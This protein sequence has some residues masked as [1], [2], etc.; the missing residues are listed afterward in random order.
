MTAYWIFSSVLLIAFAVKLLLSVLGSKAKPS[1]R[2]DRLLDTAAERGQIVTAAVVTL[3]AARTGELE[4]EQ[5]DRQHSQYYKNKHMLERAYL[6]I[7]DSRTSYRPVLRYS[8]GGRNY[9]ERY[10]SFI[11]DRELSLKDGQT[12]RICVDPD[13]PASF[14]IVGDKASYNFL[15]QIVK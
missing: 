15:T 7:P 11:S 2:Y 5:F 6:G 12:V 9:E 14:V 13:A 10:H 8:F 4:R 1:G 3:E